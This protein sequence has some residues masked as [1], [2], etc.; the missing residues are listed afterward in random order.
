MSLQLLHNCI[1][2]VAAAG[3]QQS[4]TAAQT[5]AP[6]DARPGKVM[7]RRG[8][9]SAPE[10]SKQNTLQLLLPP[11]TATAATNFRHI[12]KKQDRVASSNGKLK[13]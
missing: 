3:R 11:A 12:E 10:Q 2:V 1:V 5:E 6:P 8:S 13:N 7:P 4:S 9:G